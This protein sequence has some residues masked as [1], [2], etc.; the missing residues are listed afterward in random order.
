MTTRPSRWPRSRRA[1]AAGTARRMITP[2]RNLYTR[3]RIV[4]PRT[5]PSRPRVGPGPSAASPSAAVRGT[6]KRA[7]LP[8]LARVRGPGLGGL[9]GLGEAPAEHPVRLEQH[10]GALVLLDGELEV[11]H[12][13]AAEIAAEIDAMEAL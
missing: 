10:D 9:V 2:A 5:L 7:T 13:V 8:P 4:P 11:E 6:R 12:V 3:A 1:I